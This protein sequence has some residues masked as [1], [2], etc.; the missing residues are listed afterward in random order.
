MA[1]RDAV[2]RGVHSIAYGSPVT[3]DARLEVDLV[4]SMV[5]VAF[6]NFIKGHS[7]MTWQNL[8]VRSGSFSYRRGYNT[9]EGAFYGDGHEGVAGKFTRDH[10]DGVFGALRE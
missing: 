10:L 8:A 4:R 5:D 7:D 2:G 1:H 9:L 3:G 6:T